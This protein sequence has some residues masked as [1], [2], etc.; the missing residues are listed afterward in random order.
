MFWAVPLDLL[1]KVTTVELVVKQLTV[2]ELPCKIPIPTGSLFAWDQASELLASNR[3]VILTA[4]AEV[5][6]KVGQSFQS[7]VDGIE[8]ERIVW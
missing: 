4:L 3:H 6:A 2:P 7:P 5:N 8:R 1:P